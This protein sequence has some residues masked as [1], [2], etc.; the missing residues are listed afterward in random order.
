MPGV[1]PNI[2]GR[3]VKVVDDHD[4]GQ[5]VLDR[6][7]H[8]FGKKVMENLDGLAFCLA[9]EQAGG[10]DRHCEPGIEAGDD[11]ADGLA[12]TGAA[13]NPKGAGCL[14]AGTLPHLVGEEAPHGLRKALELKALAC[15]GVAWAADEMG[16]AVRLAMTRAIRRKRWEMG[17][18]G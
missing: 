15:D 18:H 2:R 9:G 5:L 11:A 8:Q 7:A 16:I 12:F 13:L 3:E 14:V 10:D 4:D 1:L 17:C 6:P